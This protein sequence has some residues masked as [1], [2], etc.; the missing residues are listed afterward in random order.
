MVLLLTARHSAS[1]KSTH[2]STPI[3]WLIMN[4]WLGCHF[5]S[6]RIPFT[7]KLAPS[8]HTAVHEIKWIHSKN[9]YPQKSC[10]LMQ[11]NPGDISK[12][13]HP[14]NKHCRKSA[15]LPALLCTR[16][17]VHRFEVCANVITFVLKRPFF[18]RFAL[19]PC[20]ALCETSENIDTDMAD[21]MDR[22]SLWETGHDVKQWM[23]SIIQLNEGS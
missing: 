16:H 5:I 18:T 22:Q 7:W 3:K 1:G 17:V 19:I 6:Y 15:I 9:D 12:F 13:N 10:S 14:W 8:A 21:A 4:G 11:N 20:R 23:Y 2:A